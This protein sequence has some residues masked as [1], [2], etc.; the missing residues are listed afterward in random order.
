LVTRTDFAADP[1]AALF[2]KI[3]SCTSPASMCADV[4]EP[5][6]DALSAQSAVFLQFV[7]SPYDNCGIGA[8]RYVGG[9]PETVDAYVDGLYRLDPVIQPAIHALNDAGQKVARVSSSSFEGPKH[10]DQY[11]STF[12]KPFNIGH[13]MAVAVPF[14]TDF[15]TQLS[16]IG[17]HRPYGDRPFRPEELAWFKRLVPAL[18]SVLSTITCRETL[19]I[20]RALIDVAN[21]Q[22]ADLG[23]VILD[24][25]LV[26]RSANAPGVDLFGLS[27]SA[28]AT[29]LGEVKELLLRDPPGDGASRSL[30]SRDRGVPV[31]E[32]EVRGFRSGNDRQHYLVSS[33]GSAVHNSLESACQALGFT[34]RETETARLIATGKC[35]AS[36]A[37]ELG[38]SFRTV[39]NHLRAIYRKAGVGSRTQL[40]SRL[41]HFS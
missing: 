23:Y 33:A 6:A 10:D 25:D 4:L 1:S 11:A 36:L 32:I 28:Q 27:G 35:T 24:E 13:V 3:L 41:L 34:Q 26:V 19:E 38:I 22:S 30:T 21:R 14:D 16:C 29:V 5:L 8:S 12:L 15:D 40:V 31:A 17:L 18:A 9:R 7:S 2:G 37:V 20:S 39:E